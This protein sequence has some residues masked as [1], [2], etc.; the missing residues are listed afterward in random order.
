MLT[1]LLF[2]VKEVVNRTKKGAT[3][4]LYDGSCGKFCN[5]YQ[6]ADAIAGSNHYK[7]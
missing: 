6:I 7:I 1:L 5:R 2:T 3:F 4:C